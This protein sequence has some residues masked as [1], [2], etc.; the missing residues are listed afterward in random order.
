MRLSSNS[1]YNREAQQ[2]R[3]RTKTHDSNQTTF[4]STGKAVSTFL[5]LL[6]CV[7][8]ATFLHRH[9]SLCDFL[10][11][12]FVTVRHFCAPAQ[13]TIMATRTTLKTHALAVARATSI[14]QKQAAANYQVRNG[15]GNNKQAAVRS[16]PELHVPI[17]PLSL[18]TPLSSQ[19][20]C[21]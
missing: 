10:S 19:T 13:L 17:A 7:A 14:R 21:D 1:V 20:L 12:S 9:N 3:I 16:E 6:R 18:Q 11:R 2:N 15:S 8:R 5:R 4:L